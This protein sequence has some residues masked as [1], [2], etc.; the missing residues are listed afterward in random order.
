MQKAQGGPH[1]PQV[2]VIGKKAR[3][4]R[5]Q[6]YTPELGETLAKVRT[7]GLALLTVQPPNSLAEWIQAM[8]EMTTAVHKAPGIPSAKCYRYKWVVRGF[9]DFARRQAGAAPGLTW[10]SHHTVPMEH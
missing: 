4:F 3:A 6:P 1:S 10:Q 5:I 8:S 9:W 7:F 2:L